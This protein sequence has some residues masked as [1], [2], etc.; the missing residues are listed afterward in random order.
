[1]ISPA[2]AHFISSRA[3][4]IETTIWNKSNSLLYTPK[5]QVIPSCLQSYLLNLSLLLLLS[6]LISTP[7]PTRPILNIL[8]SLNTNLNLLRLAIQTLCFNTFKY[9]GN[10]NA[11][12]NLINGI[13][14]ACWVLLPRVSVILPNISGNKAPLLTAV[15]TKLAPRLLCRPSPRRERVKISRKI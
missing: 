8:L 2:R 4:F 7:T 13:K 10:V 12:T 9:T 11:I 6:P 1:M 5:P 3:L 14:N 15:T